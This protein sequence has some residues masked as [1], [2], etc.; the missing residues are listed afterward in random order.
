MGEPNLIKTARGNQSRRNLFFGL[1]GGLK[2]RKPFLMPQMQLPIF[3]DGAQ[4]INDN[5][6]FE[7]RGN[8]VFYFNGHLPVFTHPSNDIAS[9]RLFSTQLIVNGTATQEQIVKAF[10]VSITTVKRYCRLYRKRGIR[11][12]FIPT[13]RTAGHRLT[14][15][16]LIQ[17][18]SILDQ[19]QG[20]TQISRLLGI[21]PST[22][23][24]AID[25]GR[26][27]QIRKDST[28]VEE[29]SNLTA[30]SKSQRSVADGQATMGV[31]ATRLYQRLLASLG[32][33]QATEIRFES[34]QDLPNGGVLCA[35]PR[36]WLWG[37]CATARRLSACLADIIHWKRFFYQ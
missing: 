19:G 36:S 12:F 29:V 24:K 20:V 30:S 13:V 23:H 14:P 25:D 6:A 26:L 22:L 32:K 1:L 11:G 16:L 4:I 9:F 18:Q 5:L 2:W 15:Q 35:L 28:D 7:R 27:K 37:Y 3:P 33:L 34:A 21:L 31:G 8:Q 17:V 10:G